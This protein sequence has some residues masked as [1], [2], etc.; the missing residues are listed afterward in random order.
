V[1][2]T[3]HLSSFTRKQLYRRL[4]QAYGRGDLRVVRRIQ[5]LLALAD[6]QSVEEAAE[7]L[8]LGQHT[9]RDSRHAF[10]LK[11]VLRLVSTRPSGRPST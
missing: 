5:A 2:F 6:N 7:M 9:I 3:L 8:S 1:S 4:Q 10:L 11:G